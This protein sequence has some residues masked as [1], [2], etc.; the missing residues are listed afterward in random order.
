LLDTYSLLFRA[1]HALPAMN[2]KSGEP[3]SALYG[4]NVLLLKLLREQAP[5]GL[6]FALDAPARTFRKERFDGYKA[7]RERAPSALITQLGRLE[8]LIEALGVPAFCVP[9]F[10]AD[11][12]LA[13][14]ARELREQ[15]REVVVVSGDRDIL[16][17]AKGSTSVLFVG[18]RGRK[19][20]SY[21][22]AAVRA[23][24]GV[25]PDQLPSLTALLGDTSDNLP[26]VRGIG[27][28]TAARLLQLFGDVQS[29]LGALE[30][31]SPEKLRQTL[32]EHR[33][34]ILE[35]AELARLVD[36]VA[37]P[38]GPRCAPVA[39]EALARVRAL[40]VEL[41]FE[42]LLARVDALSAGVA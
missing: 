31:V 14:L 33:Q 20:T 30:Q 25:G 23:R 2:T 35:T 17:T 40:Y 16:Q 22:E 1:H 32:A 29:L 4:L 26:G 10:E 7:Q 3:T 34:Q 9:G 12:L 38:A 39:A 5:E 41:E 15:G 21:D 37:L 6:A 11:D 36:D 13:T 24:F 28:R 42:S 19:P 27:P 18:A 8:Q